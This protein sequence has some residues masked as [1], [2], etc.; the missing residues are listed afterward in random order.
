MDCLINKKGNNAF[1]EWSTRCYRLRNCELIEYKNDFEDFKLCNDTNIKERYNIITISSISVDPK[2]PYILNLNDISYQADSI[3][4]V[5]KFNDINKNEIDHKIFTGWYR[6][7]CASTKIS[8]NLQCQQRPL[9][10]NICFAIYYLLQ[11]LYKHK[12]LFNTQF[13]FNKYKINA[14]AFKNLPSKIEKL[15]LNLITRSR[16]YLKFDQNVNDINLLSQTLLYTL[17]N[18][19]TSLFCDSHCIELTDFVMNIINNNNVTDEQYQESKAY[20]DKDI[21]IFK[22]KAHLGQIKNFLL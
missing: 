19:P 10:S 6:I 1:N 13:I 3:N 18:M 9:P 22:Q 7:L 5:L 8:S 15:Y 14:K 11:K 21:I 17:Q 2:I 20:E 16:D 4:V 12:Q